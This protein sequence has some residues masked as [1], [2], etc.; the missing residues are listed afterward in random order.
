MSS[1]IALFET[2]RVRV[3]SFVVSVVFSAADAFIAAA[4]IPETYLVV[5]STEYV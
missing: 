4:F 3:V 1:E 2:K 5:L